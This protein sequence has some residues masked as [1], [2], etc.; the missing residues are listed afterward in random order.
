MDRRVGWLDS[1]HFGRRGTERRVP[2]TLTTLY[3]LFVGHRPR[4]RSKIISHYLF[5]RK[6]NNEIEETRGSYGFDSD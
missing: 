4:M 3:R 1:C 6:K 5:I 2:D